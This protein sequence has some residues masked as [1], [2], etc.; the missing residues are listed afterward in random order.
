MDAVAGVAEHLSDHR[1]AGPADLS[2]DNDARITS[3]GDLDLEWHAWAERFTG[4]ATGWHR[5]WLVFNAARGTFESHRFKGSAR[6]AAALVA[7]G[8]APERGQLKIESI[9]DLRFVRGEDAISQKHGEPRRVNIK[10]GGGLHKLRFYDGA[11]GTC[12]RNQ[13]QM[14]RD[15]YQQRCI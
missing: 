8:Q 7:N 6:A 15:E 4:R 1:D 11:T 10:T 12:W 9:V 13:L 5:R 14:W 3:G 2:R